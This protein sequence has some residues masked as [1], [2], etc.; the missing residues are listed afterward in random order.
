MNLRRYF[1]DPFNFALLLVVWLL[2]THRFTVGN[3][4]LAAM[5]AWLIPLGVSRIRT[6]TTPVRKPI[7]L[8]AFLGVLVGDIVVSNIVVAKQV[9]G[10]PERLQPGF[11]AIP[12]DLKEALPIT[13]L[14]ST[15][16]LTPGTVSIEIT[17]DRKTLYV[18]ALHV[19]SETDLVD[20]IKYRYEKPLK[21]IFGC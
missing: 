16:S 5:L 7:R 15:I 12:L 20:R 18:H 21:E 11:V 4:L 6:T 2:L 9:L 14:A 10:V 19:E 8:F 1:P 13:I 17:K 3:L